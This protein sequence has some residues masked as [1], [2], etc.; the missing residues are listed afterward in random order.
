MLYFLLRAAELVASMFVSNL[1]QSCLLMYFNKR[2][3]SP[4]CHVMF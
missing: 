1:A 2:L 4:Y 3:I